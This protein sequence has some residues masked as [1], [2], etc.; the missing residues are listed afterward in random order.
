VVGER[1]GRMTEGWEREGGGGESDG[2]SSENEEGGW[3]GET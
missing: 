3:W 2:D 1:A